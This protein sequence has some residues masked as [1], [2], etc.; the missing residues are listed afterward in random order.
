MMTVSH[1]R[2]FTVNEKTIP[3]DN[4]FK[5]R[6]DKIKIENRHDSYQMFFPSRIVENFN[7]S[8]KN[9]IHI[10]CK[11]VGTR[12]AAIYTAVECLISTKIS[13]FN[14]YKENNKNN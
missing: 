13:T 2:K 10:N 1:D 5:M 12:N 9:C 4:S 14:A 11:I 3:G 7:G 6:F 8:E